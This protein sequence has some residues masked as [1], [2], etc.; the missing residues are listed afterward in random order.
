VRVE[1]ASGTATARWVE[2][3]P[4]GDFVIPPA[5]GHLRNHPAI[6]QPRLYDNVTVTHW[7]GACAYNINLNLN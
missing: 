4:E 3:Q 1:K 2:H 6:A 7:D 5:K